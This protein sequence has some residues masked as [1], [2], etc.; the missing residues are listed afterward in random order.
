MSNGRKPGDARYLIPVTERSPGPSIML[1]VLWLRSEIVEFE[2][3]EKDT[4]STYQE[5]WSN[6]S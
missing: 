6:F 5:G 2:C 3:I 1:W 4:Y